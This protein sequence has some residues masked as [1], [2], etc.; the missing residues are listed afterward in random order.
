MSSHVWTARL[1]GDLGPG[2]HTITVRAT[3]EYGARHVA[4][5]IFE[6]LSLRSTPEGVE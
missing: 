6:V 2:V 1:P 5:K 4:Q 3:D